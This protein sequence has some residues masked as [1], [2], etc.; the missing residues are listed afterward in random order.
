[1]QAVLV[2]VLDRDTVVGEDL[3]GEVQVFHGTMACN[4]VVSSSAER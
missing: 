4:V 3:L 2:G 1:L